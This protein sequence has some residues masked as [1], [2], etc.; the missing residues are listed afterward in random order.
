MPDLTAAIAQLNDLT[1][2]IDTA[3][4][5]TSRP[6]GTLHSCPMATH[7]ADANG[8]LWFITHNRSEKVE[9]V[10]TSQRVNVAYADHASRRYI[11][12]SGFCELVRDHAVAK[13]LWQ[14]SYES[15]LPG[16]P[17]GPG[18]VLLKV[19][20]QQVEYWDAAKGGMSSLLGLPRIM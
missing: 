16:G 13:A 19:D 8:V 15:W 1:K 14:P 10:R 4:L 11:S 17:E 18:V 6:D 12:V 2:G 9:A 7:P 20:I 5:T 3:I